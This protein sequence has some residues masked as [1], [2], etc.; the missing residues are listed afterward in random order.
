MTK[1]KIIKIMSDTDTHSHN[2]TWHHDRNSKIK[3]VHEQKFVFCE[4]M[5]FFANV[6]L[7]KKW[8]G[9]KKTF[10]CIYGIS[11]KTILCY[12]NKKTAVPQAKK[13]CSVCKNTLVQE[14]LK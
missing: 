3:T 13:F 7:V 8:F 6:I 4:L 11:V 10:Y 12:F 14:G 5:G 1:R 2:L 9:A